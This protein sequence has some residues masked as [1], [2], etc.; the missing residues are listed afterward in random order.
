MAT[1]LA[2]FPEESVFSSTKFDMVIS[3]T[4]STPLTPKLDEENYMIQHEPL[5]ND[6]VV[7]LVRFSSY[8]ERIELPPQIRGQQ[9]CEALAHYGLDS[10]FCLDSRGEL[11]LTI[12]RLLLRCTQ[13]VT[14]PNGKP[15]NYWEPVVL[16]MN[17]LCK[18]Q[19]NPRNLPFK[20]L[21]VQ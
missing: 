2:P 17:S 1:G 18:Y 3:T 20:R 11:W 4:I 12:G 10:D 7:K 15:L 5:S 13:E 19:M 14:G 8:I 9:I 6:E 16:S 21:I